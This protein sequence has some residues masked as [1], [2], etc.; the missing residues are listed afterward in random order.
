MAVMLAVD[1]ILMGGLTMAEYKCCWNCLYGFCIARTTIEE[2]RRSAASERVC[3][4]PYPVSNRA[5][6]PYKRRYCT[7]FV[8]NV[9]RPEIF[10][11]D[12]EVAE[13]LNGMSEE[14]L[15]SYWRYVHG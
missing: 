8:S 2:K 9:A 4:A 6:N 3:C 14:E 5:E 7:Q 12:K 13:K 11:I 1:S 15:V 10:M